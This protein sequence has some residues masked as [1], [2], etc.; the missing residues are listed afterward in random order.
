VDLEEMRTE[1]RE[2]VGELTA[3]FFTD[4]EVDRAINEGLRR[5]SAEEPWPWLYTEW[6]SAVIADA[7]TL[8]L[9]ANVSLGRVFNLSISGGNLLRPRLLERLEPQAG[10]QSRF[11]YSAS[12]G[13]PLFYYI[14]STNL[15]LDE[16]PPIVYTARLVPVADADYDVEALYHAVPALLS[17]ASDEPMAPIEY[18]EAIVAWATGKLFLK[19]MAISQKANEQF[20]VYQKVLEQARNDVQSIHQDEVVAWGREQPLPFRQRTRRDYVYERIPPTL[21]P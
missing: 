11:L 8:E 7:D 15:G 4:A 20:A 13:I 18:Q 21:G 12:T 16:A 17:G 3:D 10:F 5:F 19:E 6:S 14:S 2:R 1:V 9:P